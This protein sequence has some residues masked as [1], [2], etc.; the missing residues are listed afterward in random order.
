[1]N[2]RF[3][4]AFF[5]LALASCSNGPTKLGGP[6]VDL[7]VANN[8]ELPAPEVAD[9]TAFSRPFVIGPYDT[10]AIEVFGV[11]DLTRDDIRVDASGRLA[12]PLVGSIPASGMT[13]EELER[14]I[15]NRLRG[16]YVR[17]PH[18]TVNLKEMTSNVVTVEGEVNQPGMYPVVGNMTLLRTIASARGFKEMAEDQNVVVFRTVNGRKMAGLYNVEAIRRGYYADPTIYANDVVVV[19]DDEARQ[20]FRDIL[21]VVSVLTYPLVAFV[22][23]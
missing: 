10:M 13:P 20:L 8:S 1:M 17:D 3:S 23:P 2:I 9:L 16:N 14:E 4:A 15:E 18:V 22:N 19:D 12:Y 11:E 21:S 5:A 6:G 7:E